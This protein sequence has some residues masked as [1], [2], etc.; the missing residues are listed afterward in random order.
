MR[1]K[2]SYLLPGVVEV[3]QTLAAP[4]E[5]F[6]L[7]VTGG[8]DFEDSRFVW[9]TLLTLHRKYHIVELGS[10]C[11]EGVDTFAIQWAIRHRVPWRCYVADWDTYDEAA[12]AIRNS[13]YLEDFQPDLLAVF[14]GGRGTNDCARKARKMGIEREFYDPD[15]DPLKEALRWG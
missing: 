10:G 9:D 13:V 5:G 15:P 7:G 3:M 11:A 14:T 1:R 12:G 8:R 2:A 6:R 4:E